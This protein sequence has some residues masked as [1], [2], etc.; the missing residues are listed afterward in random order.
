[1]FIGTCAS[2]VSSDVRSPDLNK[3]S[4]SDIASLCSDAASSVI[5]M[6]NPSID[7]AVIVIEDPSSMN[8]NT[9]CEEKEKKLRAELA[10]GRREHSDS[11]QCEVK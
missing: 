7:S 8:M 9:E 5:P 11:C 2:A 10:N 6:E 4:K 1:M 3:T